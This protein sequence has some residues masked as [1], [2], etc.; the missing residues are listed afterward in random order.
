[1]GRP[2]PDDLDQEEIARLWAVE[3]QRRL[4]E[5]ESG[6]VRGIPAKE[7]AAKVERLLNAGNVKW[8]RRPDELS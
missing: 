5:L 2:R 6:R 4:D 1:M 8:H 3:A 7:V